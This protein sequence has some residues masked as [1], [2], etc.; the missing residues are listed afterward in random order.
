MNTYT[1]QTA[2]SPEIYSLSDVNRVFGKGKEELQVLSGVDLTL[3]EGEIV[4]MLGR[5]GS[6]KSTLLRIIAGLIEPSS[7]DVLYNGQPL[8]G[9]AEGVAMV[10]QTFALFPWL[11]VLEN[12]EAGLQ[13]LQVERKAARKRALAA[14]DLIGLD[15]FENAYPRELSGGMR[16]RVGF[17]RALVVNPTL[18]LMDEPFS[19][20]DVLTA[21][22]LR[23]DLL[24]LWSGKQLP[25][26]SIL[27]VTHNIE[28]AVLMCD[29]ILV[30]SSNPGRVVAEIKVP[31]AH[32]RNRLDP[33]FRQMVDD[34]YAQMTDRRSADA[35]AGKP[36]LKMSSPLPEVS[37]NLMAGLIET[38]AAEPY[39]GHAGLPT[40][41]ERRLLEVD[42]LF[43]VAEMIEHLGFAELKGA[44]ITLTDAGKLFADYG[45]QE[46]K[47]LFA[48][49][50]IRHVPLAA[51]IRQ[52]LL[53]RN[54]HR[55]PRVR[56]EQELQDS[57]T[58]AFVERTLEVVIAWGRYAEIF[59]YDDH[60]ETFSLEDVEG[61]L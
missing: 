50:L 29:R 5:S 19:A 25:I 43:P 7:G 4:G 17:A 36:E 44:D 24:D 61:S 27:I 46:R 41:A 22:T 45:T 59:S 51:R 40:V 58:E 15:G 18:L 30:L 39:N 6:G 56:F 1:G 2:A 23:T 31:F 32:P 47:T 9:P 49:H 34:I 26:K 11:T 28:E 57:L 8:H 3:R 55:A 21:E 42:D 33:A 35:S 16:Q 12:V 38:I 52:V 20:L 53:E 60:T 10:F 14:I 13:A 37:T 54:G 48:E